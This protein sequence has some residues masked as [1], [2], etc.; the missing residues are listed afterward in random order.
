[1]NNLAYL[2]FYDNFATSWG[3]SIVSMAMSFDIKKGVIMSFQRKLLVGAVLASSLFAAN[4]QAATL[5]VDGGWSKFF[6]GVTGSSIYDSSSSDLSYDFV[7]SGSALLKVTDAFAIG[8][9]FEIF[10]NGVSIFSTGAFDVGGVITTDPDIAFGGGAYSYGSLLL[11]AGSHKI[12]GLATA[13]PFGSGG[14]FIELKGSAVPEPATWAM[15]IIGFGL[16]GVSLRRRAVAI[17]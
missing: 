15:M 5:V 4:A 10:D 2:N 6:F 13:S 9:V 12:T 8:D 17:A 16:A 1:M 11:G 14:A 3:D 7:L